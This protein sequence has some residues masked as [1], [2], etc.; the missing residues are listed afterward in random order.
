MIEKANFSWVDPRPIFGRERELGLLSEVMRQSGP[1][2]IH[3]HGIS[4]IGKSALIADFAAIWRR[5][6][7]AVLL[8][9]GRTIEPTESGFLREASLQLRIPSPTLGSLVR[10]LT[11][12]KELW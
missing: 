7:R 6:R 8:I 5:K 12:K 4:G 9:D 1:R 2:V 11:R 3:V 10:V